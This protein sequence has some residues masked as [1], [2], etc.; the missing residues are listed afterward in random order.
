MNPAPFLTP[1]SL[2]GRPE[3]M[4]MRILLVDDDKVSRKMLSRLLEQNGYAV[5]EAGNGRAAVDHMVQNPV[6]LMV[7]AMIMPE[8]DGVETI[9]AVRH[10]FPWVKIVAVAGSGISPAETSLNI[11]QRLGADKTLIKPLA[12]EEF[13]E[14]IQALVG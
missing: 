9:L 12:P 13:L 14:A 5:A 8:M 11:A 7:T 10:Q 4:P 6:D 1:V 2:P 3:T